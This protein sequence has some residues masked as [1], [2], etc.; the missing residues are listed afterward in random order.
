[1]LRYDRTKYS[2][3]SFKI[4]AEERQII[5]DELAE[6]FKNSIY[7]LAQDR[8]TDIFDQMH[9]KKYRE[10]DEITVNMGF[11]FVF[12]DVIEI[13]GGIRRKDAKI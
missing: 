8:T 1:M 2:L 3:E 13:L 12:G 7:I 9:N 11:I 10:D 4:T 5:I 6:K